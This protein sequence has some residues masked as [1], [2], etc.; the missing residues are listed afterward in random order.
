MHHPIGTICLHFQECKFYLPILIIFTLL[1]CPQSTAALIIH[2]MI[3]RSAVSTPI[4]PYGVEHFYSNLSFRLFFFPLTFITHYSLGACYMR[5]IGSK[6]VNKAR[7]GLPAL[8]Q[9]TMYKKI[10]AVKHTPHLSLLKP[11]H[12]T[13]GSTSL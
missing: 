4:P 3:S 6:M 1:I 5:N 8:T 7:P 10:Y 12:F 13:D 11:K 2:R 9:Q